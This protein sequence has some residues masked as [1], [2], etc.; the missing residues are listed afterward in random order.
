MLDIRLA[1]DAS[2][3]SRRRVASATTTRWLLTIGLLLVITTTQIDGESVR[4]DSGVQLA[5]LPCNYTRAPRR[6]IHALL[7]RD[8]RCLTAASR[9][10]VNQVRCSPFISCALHFRFRL[11]FP[12]TS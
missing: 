11:A 12:S 9:V 6:C 7:R 5:S 2:A 8:A 10:R 3:G 1:L 4:C